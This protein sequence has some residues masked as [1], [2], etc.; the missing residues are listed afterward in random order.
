MG[1]KNLFSMLKDCKYQ[2]T[3]ITLTE[4]KSLK[5]GIDA[6]WIIH[7]SIKGCYLTN[8]NGEPTSVFLTILNNVIKYKKHDITPIYIFDNPVVTKLKQ[9]EL[10]QRRTA[11]IKHSKNLDSKRKK[12]CLFS[13]NS[14]I[15]QDVKHMLQLLGVGWVESEP[16]IE[17]E[18]LAVQLLRHKKIDYFITSDSDMILFGGDFIRPVGKKLLLYSVGDILRHLDIT[19]EQLIR[20]GIMLGT[21]FAP[22]TRGIGPKT[23]LLRLDHPLTDRQLEAEQY[24]K[25][26]ISKKNITLSKGNKAE[27]IEWLVLQKD[28]NRDFLG[29]K[30]KTF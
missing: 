3:S 30:L 21:D 25:P 17:A 8:K 7:K 5:I 23:V 10:S 11:K 14:T 27:L 24:F 6:S 12:Q 13:L 15:V 29:R 28:F 2:P 4:I 19:H 9:E 26:Y 18:K 20:M 22:K 16:E 1:V